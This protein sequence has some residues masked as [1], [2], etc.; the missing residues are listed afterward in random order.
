VCSRVFMGNILLLNGFLK[1]QSQAARKGLVVLMAINCF[2][3]VTYAI[4]CFYTLSSFVCINRITKLSFSLPCLC[5]MRMQWC[6]YKYI[7][8]KWKC[9]A[10]IHQWYPIADHVTVYWLTG[11]GEAGRLPVR[12]HHASSRRRHVAQP[13]HQ[14]GIPRRHGQ[15][16]LIDFASY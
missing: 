6:Q 13:R 1:W 7:S 11:D 8:P 2:R 4:N 16:D 12:Y 15:G 5:P 14:S 9:I 3:W 10:V